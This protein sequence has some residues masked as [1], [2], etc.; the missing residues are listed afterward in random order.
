MMK[1]MNVDHFDIDSIASLYEARQ[2]SECYEYAKIVCDL[3]GHSSPWLNW[4][5]GVCQDMLGNPFEGLL[6]FKKALEGDPYNYTYT[7]ALHT[8]LGI[9]RNELVS[10]LS[11]DGTLPY[12]QR[13]HKSLVDAG[14][15]SSTHQYLVAKNY[16]KNLKFN[17]AREILQVFLM[18]NP[19]DQE[20][21]KLDQM[22]NKSSSKSMAS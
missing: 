16:I 3:L 12:V 2:Y 8:N 19:K 20:A 4:V 17:D 21:L 10:A 9:F 7:N 15:F 11:H 5:Q 22:I 13:I 1:T 18:N 14:E 6:L